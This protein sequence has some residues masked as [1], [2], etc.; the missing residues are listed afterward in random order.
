MR[1]GLPPISDEDLHAFVDGEVSLDQR[2]DIETYLSASP[3]AVERV[4]NWRRQREIIRATFARLETEPVPPG[5][6][7]PRPLSKCAFLSLLRPGAERSADRSGTFPRQSKLWRK[8]VVSNSRC[9]QAWSDSKRRRDLASAFAAGAGAALIAA[10]LAYGLNAPYS[11]WPAWTSAPATTG[12]SLAHQTMAALAAF[13]PQKGA[14]DSSAETASGSLAIDQNA[15]VIPNL[16]SVGLA[17]VGVRAAP[18]ASGDTLCLFYAKSKEPTIALCVTRDT[19][20]GPAGFRASAQSVSQSSPTTNAMA[21]TWR[22][23]NAVYALAGSL[24]EAKLRELAD[25][26]SAEVAAFDAS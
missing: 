6:L 11:G 25:R 13:K 8:D 10:F 9:G 20:S 16:S 22:Q 3:A 5:M 21:I 18:G 15:L 4:E 17:L 14:Q 1:G 24:P 7:V 12:D 2:R 26:V 19:Q 23:G